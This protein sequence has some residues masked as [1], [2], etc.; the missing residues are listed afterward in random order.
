MDLVCHAWLECLHWIA[1]FLMR[2]G[3]LEWFLF[4]ILLR[5]LSHWVFPSKLKY[6]WWKSKGECYNTCVTTRATS[7]WLSTTCFLLSFLK[8]PTHV[9]SF[10]GFASCLSSG[11]LQ[12]HPSLSCLYIWPAS[13]VNFLGCYYWTCTI[14]WIQ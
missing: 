8:K 11:I 5:F 14:T 6:K 13:F 7:G 10:F 3:F 12:Q 2:C 4:K 1:I 9:A